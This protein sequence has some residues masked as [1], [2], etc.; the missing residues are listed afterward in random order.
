MLLYPDLHKATVPL[1]LR[2]ILKFGLILFCANSLLYG[3]NTLSQKDFTVLKSPAD[4]MMKSYL[5][6]I[7]DRQFTV[8]DSLLSTLKSAIDWDKRSQTI[9]DSMISWTGPFPERT[10]LNTRITG[11]IE[12]DKYTVENVLFE[13]RPN[14]L[15]SANLYLPKGIPFPRP[16]VLN[17]I[18]H[19]AI[20]KATEKTQRISIAQVKN[21]FVVLTIDCIGQG[22]RQISDYTSW[23]TAPGNA[24]QIIG[25]QAFICG[26][27][28]FNFMVWDAIRAIDYLVSRP[29]VNAE[30]ISITGSSGG[31]MMSTYI[32]PF[33][34]RIAVSVPTCNPNT[35]SY[36]VHANLSCDH[37]Q[38]FFGAFVS[39][40]D[41][42]GDPLFT[43][44][45]KP[46]LI[47]ATRDDHLNPPRGVWD[48]SNWLFKSY[49]AHGVPE[50]FNTSMVKA[51][52]DYNKEQRE[53][54]N[55]WM[56]RWTGG[57]AS[58]FLEEDFAIEKEKDLWAARDGSVYNEPGSR[59]PQ[60]LVL[61]YLAKHKAKWG[62]VNTD[63]ALKVHKTEM[64]KLIKSELHTNLDNITVEGNLEG[65]RQ[66][67]E[68]KLR[69]FILKPEGGIILPGIM[70]E[71]VTKNSNQDV[72]LY[73]SQNGKSD[74]LKEQDIVKK[75]L[76][77]GS[78]I[79]A[80]DLRG[81]GETSPDMAGMFWDFLSGKPIFGQRV[82]DVLA[83]IKWLKE[84]EIKAQNIKFWGKGMGALYGAFTG[85]LCDDISGLVL[86]EPLISF[87]SVVQVKVPG[88][89]EEIMLPNILEKFDM[90]QIYQALSPRPVT[91]LNPMLGD[92]TSAGNSDIEIIGKSVAITYKAIKNEKSWSMK[93]VSG[94]ERSKMILSSFSNN[95]K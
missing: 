3:Q 47:N 88:Y 44:I 70:L 71:P 25:T 87:E 75:I 33:E 15:V 30:K 45:P 21:G 22:E 93:S 46:L 48:L 64:A 1:K 39:A 76:L 17:V 92:K 4:T 43:Q 68:I 84:S 38:I 34:K 95:L 18:G 81:I 80:I 42:R 77:G 66:V 11:R 69:S 83:T 67:G 74:I 82:R 23:S 20:G 57:N 89:Q 12:R 35:W 7:V 32:L 49:S 65:Y 60:E 51:A 24:H 63:K 8:R 31:G 56:L 55:S 53:V 94:D 78:I 91:L 16:A 27:N 59:K 54:T 52:H 58:D 79:C 86:E 29:E 41:P 72:I 14:F 10:P 9:R 26:T 90:T 36:R 2:K 50:K 13:S 37:E 62:S 85:V 28:V 5:T 40:I 73:I 61:D 6:K 19:A